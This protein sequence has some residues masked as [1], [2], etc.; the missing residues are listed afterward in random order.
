MLCELLWFVAEYFNDRGMS[1]LL[2]KMEAAIAVSNKPRQTNSPPSQERERMKAL[3]NHDSAAS[4][5]AG[6][7]MARTKLSWPPLPVGEEGMDKTK[8]DIE[9]LQILTG[10]HRT[11]GGVVSS[12]IHP[13]TINYLQGEGQGVINL[14]PG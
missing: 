11:K 9:T 5:G 14:I 2:D 10:S 3:T 13:S 12:C 7:T 8:G 1:T 6:P 4:M